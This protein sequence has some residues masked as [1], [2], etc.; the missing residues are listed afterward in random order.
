[1]PSLSP[2]SPVSGTPVG[3]QIVHVGI[4][5]HVLVAGPPAADA[6][7]DAVLQRAVLRLEPRQVVLTRHPG[8]DRVLS[9]DLFARSGVASF[10]PDAVRVV[11]DVVECIAGSL[12]IGIAEV[13]GA[14]AVAAQVDPT[15]GAIPGVHQIQNVLVEGAVEERVVVVGFE[16]PVT[17][18]R[19]T[20]DPRI[21]VEAED[22]LRV[23]GGALVGDVVVPEDDVA[24]LWVGPLEA[25]HFDAQAEAATGRVAAVGV[26]VPSVV[27]IVVQHDEA[28]LIGRGAFAEVTVPTAVPTAVLVGPGIGP[29]PRVAADRRRARRVDVDTLLEV[30]RPRLEAHVALVV[31][32]RRLALAEAGFHDVGVFDMTA[33]AKLRQHEGRDAVAVVHAGS[34]GD[35]GRMEDAEIDVARVARIVPHHAVVPEHGAD[36]GRIVEPG[37]LRA[38]RAPEMLRH[39]HLHLSL[40]R[41]CARDAEHRDRH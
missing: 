3:A 13:A 12:E 16:N 36:V 23:V 25:A 9:D 7:R 5:I 37:A 2:R 35:L 17:R 18:Q 40:R 14:A 11:V 33:L 39:R 31:R 29:S 24:S 20:A 41:R 32:A 27:V 15:S 8:A 26:V 38:Q 4:P 28:L 22:D 1:M 30:A 6:I 10:I 34:L 19:R 21:H